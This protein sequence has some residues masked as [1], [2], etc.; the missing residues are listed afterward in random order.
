M[1]ATSITVSNQSPL[2]HRKHNVLDGK[3]TFLAVL[4]LGQGLLSTGLFAAMALANLRSML[5]VHAQ[6]LL[7]VLCLFF[8]NVVSANIAFLFLTMYVS[9]PPSTSAHPAQGLLR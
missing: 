7:Q 1:V 9:Q 5:V 4:R 8:V 6:I 2:F 3:I